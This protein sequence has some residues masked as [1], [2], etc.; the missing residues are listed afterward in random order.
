MGNLLKL[1]GSALALSLSGER[2]PAHD[3]ALYQE[4]GA[5]FDG[6]TFGAVKG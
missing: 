6:L 3:N 5:R 2:A 1:E 4:A